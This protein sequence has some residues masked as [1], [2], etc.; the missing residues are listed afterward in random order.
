MSLRQSGIS[1]F[2]TS[3]AGAL[4]TGFSNAINLMNTIQQQQF[5]RALAV[6]KYIDDK[7]TQA[8]ND[9]LGLSGGSNLGGSLNPFSAIPG[10]SQFNIPSNGL[11]SNIPSSS[12]LNYTP[13]NSNQANQANQANQVNVTKSEV[14][15][16]LAD[17]Y[18]TDIPTVNNQYAG[19]AA[20]QRK[21]LADSD[22]PENIKTAQGQRI[23]QLQGFGLPKDL[24]EFKLPDRNE[25]LLAAKQGDTTKVLDLLRQ[26]NTLLK[27]SKDLLT[28]Y[29][30]ARGYGAGFQEKAADYFPA[31]DNSS[32]SARSKLNK[33][34]EA[35][36]D[37]QKQISTVRNAVGEKAQNLLNDRLFDLNQSR[38]A[39]LQDIESVLHD[40]ATVYN[41]AIDPLK[42]D[43]ILG[44]YG[45]IDSGISS[46]E[47]NYTPTKQSLERPKAG[48]NI[49]S[50]LLGAGIGGVTGGIPGA[51]IGGITG[52]ISESA[53]A[54]GLLGALLSGGGSAIPGVYRAFTSPISR[55]V[56]KEGAAKSIPIVG[57]FINKVGTPAANRII[58]ATI[59]SAQNIK[60]AAPIGAAIGA[61]I[62]VAKDLYNNLFS[63]F[64]MTSGEGLKSAYKSAIEQGKSPK[65]AAKL[66]ADGHKEQKQVV[67]QKIDNLKSSQVIEKV[68]N[69]DGSTTIRLHLNKLDLSPNSRIETSTQEEPQSISPFIKNQEGFRSKAYRDEGGKWT[70]GY[71]STHINGKPITPGMTISKEEAEQ[72]FQSDYSNAENLINNSVQV[73]LLENQK[74]ALKSFIYNAGPG[75]F[76]K[77]LV[78][79]LNKGDVK[80][81]LAQMSKFV[82]VDSVNGK[83]ISQGLRNRR[84]KEI[85]LFLGA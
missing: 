41:S 40:N 75:A 35:L 33:K 56:I 9:P 3:L 25:Y 10:N 60:K 13:V 66:I 70:I 39:I 45:N 71:G 32:I 4:P 44:D 12:G 15:N 80:G 17:Y 23:D 67:Q 51:A 7:N 43:Y 50:A 63:N 55:N 16:P 77:N 68:K 36:K 18:K 42:K 73:P 22:L 34:F 28:N 85:K 30:N 21:G 38:E 64:D 62:G 57:E 54:L 78:P 81:A 26:K 52:G 31:L 69:E 27:E 14:K 48:F 53:P 65:E 79:Y 6:N 76:Q 59:N 1:Q 82:Y 72:Q 74:E 20:Y 5:I 8:A 47:L 61:G 58:D 11:S 49:G 46:Q 2:A 29:P 83:R 84:I 19:W 37:I 24:Y